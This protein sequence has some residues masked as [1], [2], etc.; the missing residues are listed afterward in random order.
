MRKGPGLA[1]GAGSPDRS[2]KAGTSQLH[3]LGVLFLETEGAE[4]E[5]QADSRLNSPL[6]R[7]RSPHPEIMT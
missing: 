6:D 3:V 7:A 4:G 5:S 2:D 1:G